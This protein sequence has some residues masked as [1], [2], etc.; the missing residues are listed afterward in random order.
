[1]PVHAFIALGSNLG[2]RHRFLSR[3]I[4]AIDNRPGMGVIQASGIHET[5]PVGGP[6]GQRP[7]LNAVCELEVTVS[8]E[9]LL[10]ELHEIEAELGR[11]RTDRWG[12]RPIDLDILF[13]GD[14]HLQRPELEIP[15]PLLA[16]RAFVLAPLV[17]IAP[18]LIHPVLGSSITDLHR[19]L[20]PTS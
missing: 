10:N 20:V 8:P 3:A 5:E 13:Y 7:Y 18:S 14:L 2:N 11:I 15:H 4:H 12:P 9:R 19:Q 1:M 6:P 16:E 17:E